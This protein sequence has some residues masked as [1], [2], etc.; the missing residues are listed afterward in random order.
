MIEQLLAMLPDDDEDG[1][2]HGS[3]LI[4]IV[5]VLVLAILLWIVGSFIFSHVGTAH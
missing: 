4:T 2:V 3:W 5:L 1:Q